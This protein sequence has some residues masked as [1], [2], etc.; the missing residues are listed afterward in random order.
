MVEWP[1]HCCRKEKGELTMPPFV[2]PGPET[3]FKNYPYLLLLIS[4]LTLVYFARK[5]DVFQPFY[6][7]LARKVKSK[8]TVV[9]LTS[10]FGGILPIEGRIVVS[11]GILSTM[12]PD[13][14]EKKKKFALVDYLSTHH[15]YFWSP[16]EATVLVPM[17]ALGLSYFEWFWAIFPLFVTMVICTLVYIYGFLTEDDID[18]QVRETREVQ[19]LDTWKIWKSNLFTIGFVA[20]LLLVI[21]IVGQYNEQLQELVKWSDAH[22]GVVL[23]TAVLFVASL[24]LGSSGKYAGLLAI[25]LPIY[26]VS[27]IPLFVA[28]SWGGYML[29]PT[30]KCFLIGRRLFGANLKNYY[31]VV[32]VVVSAVFLVGVAATVS[33]TL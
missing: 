2:M 30:H 26:G 24:I 3:L 27:Y 12:A 10:A 18:I 5:Y 13:D 14:P 32:L 22:G 4:V 23:V 16:L 33:R 9:M 11:G 21:S 15:F 8:R 31:A 19:K 29:S 6:Y 7:W 1:L 25:I 17:A 20:V 28:A